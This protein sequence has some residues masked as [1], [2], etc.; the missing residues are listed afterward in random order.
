MNKFPTNHLRLPI[1][2][3]AGMLAVG[4]SFGGWTVKSLAQESSSSTD[5]VESVEQPPTDEQS[6]DQPTDEV[7]D[8]T[9]RDEIIKINDQVKSKKQLIENLN[10]Q[11][12]SRKKEI[13][14]KRNEAA[15]LE[16]QI[17]ILENR[18]AKTE[19][20]LLET[21]AEIEAAEL[22]IRGLGLAIK[23]KSSRMEKQKSYIA[24]YLRTI[25]RYDDRGYLEILLLNDSFSEFF[26]HIK[27][28]EDVERDLADRLTGLRTL[29]A[30]LEDQKSAKEQK[31][32]AL[33]E[34]GAKLVE[35]RDRLAEE[36]G[37]KQ[38]LA[39][40]ATLTETQLRSE[41]TQL[42]AE[43]TAIDNEIVSLENEMRRKLA[44][45]DRFADLGDNVVLTWPVDPSRGITTYFHDPE[46]PFRYVFEHPGLDIRA[47]QG[48]A[49]KSAA[50]G[51]VARTKYGGSKGYSYVMII[52]ADGISTV[53]GH[54]SSILV[55]EEQFVERG[56][57]IAL[58]GGMPGTPGAGQLTTGPHLHFEVRS[59]G[60]PINPLDYLLK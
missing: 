40:A 13:A 54:V 12:E 25:Y 19:L 35:A 51:F 56:D 21:Q 57:A 27:F 3:L 52:H 45:S 9:T 33:D 2:A 34:L 59:N 15:T 58:S 60:I 11:I 55:K 17:G 7:E 39:E 1:L 53:Y 49:V 10:Q 26:D 41:L 30:A 20:D 36:R 31:K 32:T 4:F 48:T 22:E 8:T 14:R 23:D 50:P 16:N 28:L 6:A 38:A 46:Y 18:T 43:Q 47:G 24:E 5:E 44:A 29:R 42:R 37:D